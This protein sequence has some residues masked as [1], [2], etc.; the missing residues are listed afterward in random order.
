MRERVLVVIANSGQTNERS[1]FVQNL[2]HYA[3]HHSLDFADV[4]CLA[5]ANRVDDVLGHRYRLRIGAIGGRL[6]FFVEL[7]V[8]RRLGGRV[9]LKSFDLRFLEAT[10]YFLESIGRRALGFRAE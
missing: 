6:C 9:E 3:L 1:L 7:L 4:G 2:I 5:D 8:A 10:D